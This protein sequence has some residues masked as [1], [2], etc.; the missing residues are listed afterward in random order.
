MRKL[1]S[2]ESV[3]SFIRMR[4]EGLTVAQIAVENGVSAAV[5]YR[6]LREAKLK[7][8]NESRENCFASDNS[9]RVQNIGE[10]YR[11]MILFGVM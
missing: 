6:R 2:E 9:E 10:S 1:I 3:A 5:V 11:G 4:E 7:C 8:E